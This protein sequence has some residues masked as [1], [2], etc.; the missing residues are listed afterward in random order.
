MLKKLLCLMLLALPAWG[1]SLSIHDEDKLL[2]N[3]AAFESVVAAAPYNVTIVISSQRGHGGAFDYYIDTAF[4]S[5]EGVTLGVDPGGRH[6]HIWAGP[7]TRIPGVKLGSI[8][9][10]GNPFFRTG[11]WSGGVGKLLSSVATLRVEPPV[12]ARVTTPPPQQLS[13][14]PPGKEVDWIAVIFGLTGAGFLI[15][16]TVVLVR[17]ARKSEEFSRPQ[18]RSYAAPLDEVVFTR[19]EAAN[20][21]RT[22]AVVGPGYHLTA[23]APVVI[24]QQAGLTGSPILDYMVMDNLMH[25]HH[26]EPVRTSEPT[27]DYRAA[28]APSYTPSGGGSS[29][30]SDFGSFSSDSSSSSGSSGGSDW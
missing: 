16:L 2:T 19:S 20:T 12:A 14:T 17:K 26:N 24:Q 3:P 13:P 21:T 23:P 25:S 22:R 30:G 18:V 5:P 11:D 8:A 28:P 1:G 27:H 6:T 4:A 7:L 9:V 29:G 15:W 10:E